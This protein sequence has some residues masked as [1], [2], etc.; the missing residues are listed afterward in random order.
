[1]NRIAKGGLSFAAGAAAFG[2]TLGFGNW[3]ETTNAQIEACAESLSHASP[4]SAFLPAECYNGVEV[5]F[6]ATEAQEKVI[7]EPGGRP[8]LSTV[9]KPQLMSS[10]EYREKAYKRQA[11]QKNQVHWQRLAALVV[12]GCVGG[13]MYYSWAIDAPKRRAAK[14]ATDP[15]DS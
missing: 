4:D 13:S 11:E 15:S 10:D 9:Y 5:V 7:S 12:G 2:A 8:Y 14:Q 6:K 1:M 3:P